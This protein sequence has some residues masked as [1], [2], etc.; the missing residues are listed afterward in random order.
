MEWG[1]VVLLC[2]REAG[3]GV[4]RGGGSA[5]TC[6]SDSRVPS[7]CALTHPGKVAVLTCS[8]RQGEEEEEIYKLRPANNTEVLHSMHAASLNTAWATTL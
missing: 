6:H 3:K 1:S 4:G 7:A 2:Q 5:H 8:C